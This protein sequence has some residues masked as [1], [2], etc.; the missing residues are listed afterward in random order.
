MVILAA[1][2][3]VVA[4]LL[5]MM[6]VMVVHPTSAPLLMMIVVVSDDV[7]FVLQLLPLHQLKIKVVAHPTGPGCYCCCLA[8]TICYYRVWW[9]VWLSVKI[10]EQYC[11]R[12]TFVNIHEYLHMIFG[13]I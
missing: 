5:V 8:A 10:C 6:V 4:V 1:V 13:T 12:K 7:V 3:V 11:V 2:V 9:L